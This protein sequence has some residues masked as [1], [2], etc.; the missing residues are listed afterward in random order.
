MKILVTATG[1]AIGQGIIKSI[2]LS[3]LRCG[4]V[5]TDAQSDSAGLFR[6]SAGYIVPLANDDNFIDE[7]IKIC[8]QENIDAIFIG[9][10]YE[11]LTFAEN[12]NRIEKET[13]AKVVV[14]SPRMVK[15]AEDK[16][17]THKF[18]VENNFP[19]IP[20]TL[21][22]NIDE[23]LEMEKF[24]LILKPRIGD[25][26]K[27][28]FIVRNEDELREKISLFENGKTTNVYMTKKS[29]PIIQKYISEEKEEY[30]STTLTF[31]N[32][33]YGVL[34][35]R[36]E[37]R[38]GGH[39]TKAII[40]DYPEIN[41]TI[42]NIAEKFNA[43]GPANFQS[44]FYDGLPRIFEINCRFSGTTPFCAGVGFNTVEA[45]MRHAIL[46]EPIQELRYEKGI[47]LRYF[48]E[49][50]VPLYE[51]DKL[52]RDSFIKDPKSRV[53]NIF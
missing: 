36:R 15:I 35:M 27:D 50:F 29:E 1:G 7:I 2:K 23:L 37:M 4:I 20:S 24:P 10:D 38:F 3:T 40:D 30:T 43:F 46:K 42:K 34:S 17:L 47:M 18:L 39:T 6:G 9:T 48:N 52:Q 11:L 31:N 8:N 28:T 32:H 13:N 12:K 26:S 53:N 41:K 21:H 19:S 25:S 22:E 16:W 44:R 5:T 14:S 33:C 51:F 45:V 49:V